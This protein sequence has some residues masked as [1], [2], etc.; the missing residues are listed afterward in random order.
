MSTVKLLYHLKSSKVQNIVLLCI[1]EN[2][3]NCL[4]VNKQ[5][6]L[7]KP[8]KKVKFMEEHRAQEKS[9]LSSEIK[10]SLCFCNTLFFPHLSFFPNTIFIIHSLCRLPF[11]GSIFSSPCITVLVLKFTGNSSTA[12]F[13]MKVLGYQAWIRYPPQL[14]PKVGLNKSLF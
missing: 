5:N 9:K 6:Y 12:N 10:I 3:V 4:N 8:K 13:W 2:V 1:V 7:H 14:W 11:S